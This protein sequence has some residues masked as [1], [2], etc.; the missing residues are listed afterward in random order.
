MTGPSI[1]GS[2][3]HEYY[4]QLIAAGLA[5]EVGQPART[6]KQPRPRLYVRNGQMFPHPLNRVIAKMP[7]NQRFE[8]SQEGLGLWKKGDVIERH[9]DLVGAHLPTLLGLRALVPTQKPAYKHPRTIAQLQARAAILTRLQDTARGVAQQ[10]KAPVTNPAV[11]DAPI[12]GVITGK[13]TG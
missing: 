7:H 10:L 8:V 3:P 5:K 4:D 9:I 6:I 1:P 2:N 11:L 12:V 13:V